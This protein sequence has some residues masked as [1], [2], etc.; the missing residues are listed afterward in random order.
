MLAEPAGD[1]RTYNEHIVIAFFPSPAR[2]HAP[3]GNDK[4]LFYN[5]IAIPGEENGGGI[6]LEVGQNPIYNS[7]QP[8]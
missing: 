5:T 8:E 3:S 1:K 7:S 2:C 4:P 6:S